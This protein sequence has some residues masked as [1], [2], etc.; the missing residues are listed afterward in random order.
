MNQNN[1][2]DKFKIE[3]NKSVILR[4]IYNK[5]CKRFN[6]F[7]N[8]FNNCKIL[9]KFFKTRNNNFNKISLTKINKFYY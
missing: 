2:N 4:I 5:K 3:S 6:N 7:Y 9:I 1:P 8:K